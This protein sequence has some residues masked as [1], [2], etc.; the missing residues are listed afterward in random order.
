MNTLHRVRDH[1]Q[2]VKVSALLGFDESR[3]IAFQI[4]HGSPSKLGLK[5][6][7]TI[8]RLKTTSETSTSYSY[9][10]IQSPNDWRHETSTTRS[11]SANDI[12]QS[13]H[14]D[15]DSVGHFRRWSLP[16]LPSF[17]SIATV[18]AVELDSIV[19]VD[20]DVISPAAEP[21]NEGLSPDGISW[22]SSSLYGALPTRSLL[23][24]SR[25]VLSKSNRKLGYLF[26]D[27]PLDI[28]IPEIEEL[29]LPALLSSRIPL[30]WF[31]A[32]TLYEQNAENLLFWVDSK[33]FEEKVHSN[34]DNSA[35]VIFHTYLAS[36]AAL[37]INVSHRCLRVV[38]DGVRKGTRTCFA[39][40][41]EEVLANLEM[42]FSRFYPSHPLYVLMS[43][44]LGFSRV[45][46]NQSISKIKQVLITALVEH[47]VHENMPSQIRRR[48]E[49]LHAKVKAVAAELSYGTL[50]L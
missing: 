48:N 33:L 46:S 11:T 31:L 10:T 1:E 42:A 41:R 17:D 36:D 3:I 23:A 19:V 44:D 16:T 13:M 15:Q 18:E 21:V 34:R 37:E 20:Q 5:L 43:T 9:G 49:Y 12:Q 28:T 45:A 25:S 47:P 7:L 6:G 30:L 35:E 29:R 27:A 24:S 2:R 14:S 32:M 4:G 39:R 50:N 22:P 26:P 8:P 38:V 40:A